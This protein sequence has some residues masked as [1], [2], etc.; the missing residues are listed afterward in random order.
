MGFN[1]RVVTIR[2]PPL[3][4]G[5]ALCIARCKKC[6]LR[7]RDALGAYNAVGPFRRTIEAMMKTLK[8]ISETTPRFVRRA[9]FL[10]V[11]EG[12]NE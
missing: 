2:T 3:Y 1:T 11:G 5:K 4:T 6:A 12:E 10:S 9:M 8:L 7:V